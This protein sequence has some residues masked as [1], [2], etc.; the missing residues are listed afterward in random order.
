MRSA[1]SGQVRS[2]QIRLPDAVTEYSSAVTRQLRAVVRKLKTTSHVNRYLTGTGAEVTMLN[3]A[4][5]SNKKYG[6]RELC[7]NQL[8]ATA[9]S[10]FDEHLKCHQQ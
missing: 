2:G 7:S 3:E 6:I 9:F 5:Q 1:R 8:R 4:S 10:G